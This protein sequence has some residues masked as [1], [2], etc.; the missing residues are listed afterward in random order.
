MQKNS[1]L[2]KETTADNSLKSA[3]RERPSI[4]ASSAAS[5]CRLNNWLHVPEILFT[6][7]IPTQN[8]PNALRF[9]ISVT[10]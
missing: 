5:S 7:I 2:P 1:Y 8:D 4:E 3:E 6:S 9:E 10:K